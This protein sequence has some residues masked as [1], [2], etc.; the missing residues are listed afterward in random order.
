MGDMSSKEQEQDV[1]SGGPS[2][3]EVRELN[4][5]KPDQS[6][7]KFK[8][9]IP[10]RVANVV[11]AGTTVLL[12]GTFVDQIHQVVNNPPPARVEEVKPDSKRDIPPE[13]IIFPQDTGRKD[14]GVV[15]P[16]Y[17]KMVFLPTVTKEAM[18]RYHLPK[19]GNLKEDGITINHAGTLMNPEIGFALVDYELYKQ[20]LGR[21][22]KVCRPNGVEWF[23]YNAR[24]GNTMG[25]EPAYY[26][27]YKDYQQYVTYL[28]VFPGS[29]F[30]NSTLLI[31]RRPD[32]VTEVHW[33]LFLKP[34]A[35]P[36]AEELYNYSRY[37]IT[38]EIN[39]R[40]ASDSDRKNSEED[41]AK[42][43]AVQGEVFQL[44]YERLKNKQSMPI[45]LT[46]K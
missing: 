30:Q 5:L 6:K 21:L 22:A 41:L 20:T 32:G 37:L 40:M 13:G 4:R 28:G 31:G 45:Q 2:Q 24:A 27:L 15:E 8:S 1:V 46:I 23:I 42:C 18:V 19:I 38:E 11:A 3:E 44:L 29:P 36:T 35:Q 12:G 7:S 9:K 10:E 16:V 25:P 39:G 14:G 33:G 26:Y 43:K 34:G 17:T